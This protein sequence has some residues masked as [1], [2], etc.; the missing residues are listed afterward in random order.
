MCW[1]I[2][3]T[4]H[5]DTCTLDHSVGLLGLCTVLCTQAVKGLAYNL[6]GLLCGVFR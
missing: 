2:G 4:V 5:N 6:V 3:V 1:F